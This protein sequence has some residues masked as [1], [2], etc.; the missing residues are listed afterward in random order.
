LTW[1]GDA[2]QPLTESQ[3]LP[4]DDLVQHFSSIEDDF[5]DSLQQRRGDAR[6]MILDAVLSMHVFLLQA[7]EKRVELERRVDELER[8]P[9]LTYEGVWTSQRS[10]YCLDRARQRL[11]ARGHGLKKAWR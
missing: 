9:T 7:R 4:L 1:W 11:H 3:S 8:R 10:S 6:L 2:L 5:V